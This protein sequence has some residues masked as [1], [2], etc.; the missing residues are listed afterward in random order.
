MITAYF[1]LQE[2]AGT[3]QKKVL[4]WLGVSETSYRPGLGEYAECESVPLMQ[5]FGDLLGSG[6]SAHG[7]R[8]VCLKPDTAKDLLP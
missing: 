1:W 7:A 2:P 3:L 6:A 5:E 4:A 8:E